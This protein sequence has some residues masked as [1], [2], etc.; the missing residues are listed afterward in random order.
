MCT[1]QQH[2]YY[3]PVYS[4]LKPNHI[5]CEL[6]LSCPLSHLQQSTLV[7]GQTYLL[8]MRLEYNKYFRSLRLTLSQV[9]PLCRVKLLSALQQLM[10]VLQVSITSI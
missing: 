6:F 10:V 3:V 1:R 8:G 9:L 2:S 5:Y 7:L 4:E